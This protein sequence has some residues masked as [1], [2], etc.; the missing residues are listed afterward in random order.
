VHNVEDD[1]NSENPKY[2]CVYTKDKSIAMSLGFTL[3]L[4]FPISIFQ[5]ATSKVCVFSTAPRHMGLA[6]G[7]YL[8]K[9]QKKKWIFAVEVTMI[10]HTLHIPLAAGCKDGTMRKPNK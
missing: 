5:I 7:C 6:K 1:T 10:N 2:Q 8:E 3:C 9:L 4:Q